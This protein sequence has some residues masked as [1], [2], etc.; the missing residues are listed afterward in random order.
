VPPYLWAALSIYPSPGDLPPYEFVVFS[1]SGSV[2][3][4]AEP[5]EATY[6][7]PGSPGTDIVQVSDSNGLTDTISILIVDTA[8]NPLILIPSSITLSTNDVFSFTAQGGVAPY[9]YSVFSG[10]GSI[11]AGTGAFDAPGS[12]GTTV[13]HVSDA[14]STIRSSTVTVIE[15]LVITPQTVSVPASNELQFSAAGGTGPYAYSMESGAGSVSPSGLYTAP[16]ATGTDRVRVTDTA[17]RSRVATITVTPQQPIGVSPS[18]IILLTGGTFD[19]TASG[20][21]SPYSYSVFSGGGSINAAGRYTA[22][23][24]PG[25]ATIRV[26]DDAGLTADASVVIVNIGPLSISPASVTV[27]QNSVFDFLTSGGTPQYSYTIFSGSGSVNSSTGEYMAPSALGNETVRVTDA[28]L[29]TD[30]ATVFVAPAAPTNL[31]VDGFFGGPQDI[32]LTWTDNAVGED[33]FRIERKASGGS[34]TE[35]G[36]VG[37]GITVYVDGGL[38]PN[39]PVSYR[40]RAYAGTVYSSYSNDDFAIPNP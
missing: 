31:V 1:G 37:S 27:E 2:A 26:Q 38:T 18:S 16:A 12:S 36:T 22:P 23:G 24:T 9:S 21:I 10:G 35:I 13:V 20:G 15:S 11:N 40:V 8:A 6:T 33:G 4:S 34:F 17:G 14:D 5:D 30:D 25:V 29:N 7:A 19:F 32:R 39:E 28:S 3:P